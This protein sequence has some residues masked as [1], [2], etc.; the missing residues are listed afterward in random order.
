MFVVSEV[1]NV[2]LLHGHQQVTLILMSELINHLHRRV[3][4]LKLLLLP[5]LKAEC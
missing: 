4:R 3:T 2:F 5:N 1:N